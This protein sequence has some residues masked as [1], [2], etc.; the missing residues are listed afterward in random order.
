MQAKIKDLLPDLEHRE[1]V[2]DKLLSK[3]EVTLIDNVEVRV[4]LKGGQRWARVPALGD[5]KVRVSAGRL[6]AESRPAARRSVG[7]GRSSSTRPKSN[8]D[9]PNELVALHAVPGR[10]A[11]PGRLQAPR[12]SSP[13]TNGWP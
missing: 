9:A 3:G 1:L 13:P 5:D 10:P 7:H 8:A 4:D 6:G 11:G 2:K 12:P